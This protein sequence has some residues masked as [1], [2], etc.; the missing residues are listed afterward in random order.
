MIKV[1]ETRQ[2]EFDKSSFL[3]DL[4]KHDS[5]ALYIE[6]LQKIHNDKSD[7]QRIKI[8]PTILMDIVNV[9]LEFH[10]KIPD[11]QLD[12]VLH[13]TELE[14]KKIQD[15]YLKG[16]SI[17]DLALQFD[18]TDKIIEMIL[19]NMNLKIVSDFK[20]EKKRYWRKRKK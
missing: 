20:P 17:D 10:E 5:G 2:L 7:G 3:I 13:L 15:R 18:T 12:G 8:N 9:L 1:L 11:R 19:R 4:V 6:I 16:V 14:K